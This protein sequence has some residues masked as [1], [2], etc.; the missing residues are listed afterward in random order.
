M[1]TSTSPMAN[2]SAQM[3]LWL[4]P[5]VERAHVMPSAAIVVGVIL[6]RLT[7][8]RDRI[9]TLFTNRLSI[10]ELQEARPTIFNGAG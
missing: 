6:I 10:S 8:S 5:A 2:G 1:R 4:L 9:L 3:V 7:G